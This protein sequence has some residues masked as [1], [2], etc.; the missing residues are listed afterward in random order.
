MSKVYDYAMAMEEL[1][2]DA[3]YQEYLAQMQEES[4]IHPEDAKA[5]A[6]AKM[7]LEE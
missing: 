6:F 7:I 4:R 5:H 2:N 1:G 3:E